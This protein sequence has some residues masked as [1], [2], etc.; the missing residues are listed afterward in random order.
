LSI[1]SAVRNSSR[2]TYYEEYQTAYAAEKRLDLEVGDQF[3][4]AH[5]KRPVKLI[6]REDIDGYPNDW[7]VFEN[8]LNIHALSRAEGIIAGGF[9]SK[10]KYM[11]PIA[12]VLEQLQ[13][14]QQPEG[15]GLKQPPFELLDVFEDRYGHTQLDLEKNAAASVP[16][17]DFSRETATALV[18]DWYDDSWYESGSFQITEIEVDGYPV[19]SHEA[20]RVVSNTFDTSFS[21][22]VASWHSIEF[23]T[24]Y[25][26]ESM[27]STKWTFEPDE[28]AEDTGGENL[29]PYDGTNGYREQFPNCGFIEEDGVQKLRRWDESGGEYHPRY[30]VYSG[31]VTMRV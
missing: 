15:G 1:V 18:E 17:E 8:E 28:V 7:F 2:G 4:G 25:A 26:E 23:A 21:V 11:N 24:K 6:M 29:G 19:D 31:N 3:E 16:M 5:T 13:T 14:G 9:V 12:T 10:D 30:D 27:D 20:Y 22:E